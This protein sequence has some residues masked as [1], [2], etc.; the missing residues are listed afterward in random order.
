MVLHVTTT[1]AHI[2]FELP[3]RRVERIA[4][5][6]V[7]ILMGVVGARIA[8]D[9]DLAAGQHQF[10]AHLEQFALVM[11]RMLALDDHAYR[12][13]AVEKLVQLS[14]AL[15]D[16][17]FKRGRMIHVTKRNLQRHC[18][19]PAVGAEKI[20]KCGASQIDPAQSRR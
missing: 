1:L 15:A 16:S 19:S 10:D 7:R 9:N 14:R 6:D 20:G 12:G 13:N 2:I 4:R 17:R 3:S 5:R 18:Q 8:P 11:P